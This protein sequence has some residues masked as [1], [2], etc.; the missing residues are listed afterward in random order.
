MSNK[1]INSK[2]IMKIKLSI[3][4]SMNFQ[5]KILNKKNMTGKNY[6]A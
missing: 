1:E 5:I 6:G 4:I 2:Y 3:S